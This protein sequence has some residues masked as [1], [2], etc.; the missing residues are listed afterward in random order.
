MT[1]KQMK[2]GLRHSHRWVGGV[3]AI[4]LLVAGLTGFLLQ[5]PTWLGPVPNPPLAVAVDPADPG[6]L[7]RGTHWGVEESRDDGETWREIN[8]LAPPT[9]VVRIIFSPDSPFVIHALGR[10]ALVR[11][12]D[13]GRIWR[14][15]PV[16][17][18]GLEPGT[19]FLD[20]GV[21]PG[22]M[23]RLLT[24]RGL[25]ASS[26][27]GLTWAGEGL[28]EV[29]S[30][31]NLRTMIHDLHTGHILGSA[32]RRLAEFGALALLF[33]TVTGLVL[34]RRNGKVFRR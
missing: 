30:S 9:D 4:F 33:I 16:S 23:L 32:G 3:A 24:D 7:L 1:E 5:H 20:L 28:L 27:E 21:G 18:A 8:M 15:I 12:D 10:D 2:S 25:I 17:A 13:G 26:D 19:V 14:D 6:R 34:L 31:T 22:G 11:S 29:S